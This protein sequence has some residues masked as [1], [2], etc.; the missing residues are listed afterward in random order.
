MRSWFIGLLAFLLTAARL[1]AGVAP[2]GPSLAADLGDR[3][4]WPWALTAPPVSAALGD[5]VFFLHDDGLHGTE[6][7]A[8]DGTAPGTRIVNDL[9]PGRCGIERG[10]VTL[11]G[12]DSS[13][14]HIL[15]P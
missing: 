8:S 3:V 12:L 14:S 15:F 11:A 10:F 13:S 9:C 1:V 7:W 4:P 6:L 2:V 5:E